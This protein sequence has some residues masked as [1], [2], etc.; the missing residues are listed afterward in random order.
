[1]EP[2]L[3]VKAYLPVVVADYREERVI[4]Y[5]KTDMLIQNIDQLTTDKPGF[6]DG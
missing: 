3:I 4:K 2:F 1:M 6:R 5:V